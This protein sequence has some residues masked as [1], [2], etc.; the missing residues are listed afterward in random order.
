MKT[1][2][3]REKRTAAVLAL[4]ATLLASATGGAEQPSL[5]GI[6]VQTSPDKVTV[7][8]TGNNSGAYTLLWSEKLG[9][10]QNWLKAGEAMTGSG[11]SFVLPDGEPRGPGFYR[12]RFEGSG[13]KTVPFTPGGAC[14]AVSNLTWTTAEIYQMTSKVYVKG[15]ISRIFEFGTYAESGTFGQ[16]SYW[17]SSDGTENG[18]LQVFRSLY[19]NGEK[20]VFGPDIRVGDEVVVYG[21][22]MNYRGTTPETVA[23]QS[24]LYSLNGATDAPGTLANPYTPVGAGILVTNLAWTSNTDYEK[25]EKVYVKGRISRIADNGTYAESGTFGQASYWISDDGTE[26]G[27]MMVFRSLYFNGEKY[28]SGPDI[29]VGDEVVVYGS[30]MNYKGTTP[31]TVA[32]ESWLVSLNGQTE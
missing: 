32:A 28:V 9:T 24:W 21:S 11:G 26:N 17:I 16:A 1:R 25:T 18:E 4:V 22:L 30:L 23:N 27:E 6:E 19:F 10:E 13:S 20:Y 29:H 14:V 12:A 31:E 2:G 8:G 3:S 5:T 15:I 7:S